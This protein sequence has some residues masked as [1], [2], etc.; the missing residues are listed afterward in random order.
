M[1]LA[2][3]FLLASCTPGPTPTTPPTWTSQPTVTASATAT[4][5]LA[6]TPTLTPEPAWYAQIDP[7]Y[8]SLEYRY[9][10]VS[11]PQA[12]VYTTLAD[13]ANQ[14]GNYGR[15]WENAPAYVTVFGE[16]TR[17]D[18]LYYAASY[19]WMAA[20]DVQLVTPS[21]FRG[22]LLTRQVDFRFGWVLSDTQ[23]V[24]AAGTPVQA[25]SRYQVVHEVP[26]LTENPGYVAIG[27]DE[28]LPE[29]LVAL[30][31]A[32]VPDDAG[33]G[34]CRF[35]YVDLAEQTL[36]VYHECR[37]VF[38]TLVSTG[39]QEGWTF[40]G[41]F[42]ILAKFPYNRLTP[43]E[44]SIS[45]YYLENVPNFMTYYGDL[46][47]HGAY[48]HDDFGSPVSHGCVNM[49]PGDARWLYEWA[50][51]GERVVISRGE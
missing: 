25:Y 26:A 10:L 15:P 12:K 19:G 39:K 49:S 48:W 14:T 38:A 11:D 6:P 45:V 36:R 7:S 20:G 33:E 24:N 34:T 42:A 32:R 30:T 18:H 35:I 51:L 40:P 27:P 8:S 2:V 47:F 3:I 23:S 31:S 41:R 17:D 5:T 1:L 9:G 22:I 43:P 50:W 28:W 29:E 21:S 37:L 13:A 44:E 46:G 16:A 4:P